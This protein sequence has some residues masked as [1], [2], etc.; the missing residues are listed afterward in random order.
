VA[1]YTNHLVQTAGAVA[2]TAV[3][4]DLRAVRLLHVQHE[5]SLFQDADLTH[6]AQHARASSVPMVVTEHAVTGLA[7]AWEREVD[8]LVALTRAGAEQLRRHWPDQ[9]V[10]HIPHGCPTW[11]PP[12]K[13]ERGCVIGAFGFLERHKGY[14]R[15]LDVVR[16][17]PGVELVLYSHSKRP[18]IAA[19]WD[20]AARGLPVHRE[21]AFLPVDEVARRLAG[22]ADVLVFWYDP[23]AFAAASGAV[24]VGLA[25][26]VPVL[27][28]PTGWF[29]DLREVTYQPDDLV[30][31]IQRLLRD[32]GLRDRLTAAA[33]DYCHEHDWPRIAE[34]HLTLWRSLEDGV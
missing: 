9:R 5:P 24:R 13:R 12:R 19:E 3:T 2:A 25:T 26:G 17:L 16:E 15:L 6:L 31:G 21:G 11:F 33:R 1:E 7:R 18:A 20:E 4:P 34:R 27:T 29:E 30:G 10:E 8:A 14:W 23:P 32:S 28:S 22:E